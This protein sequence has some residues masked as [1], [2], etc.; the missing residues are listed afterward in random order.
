MLS[1]PLLLYL[2]PPLHDVSSLINSDPHVD[3]VTI[4]L[5]S[6]TKNEVADGKMSFVGKG[7]G[8]SLDSED[9]MNSEETRKVCT[10]PAVVLVHAA[11]SSSAKMASRNPPLSCLRQALEAAVTAP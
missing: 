6:D 5:G 7:K 3:P 8:V 9:N 11:E 4:A 1:S 10:W 2:Q